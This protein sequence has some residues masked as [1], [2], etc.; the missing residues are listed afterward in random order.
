MRWSDFGDGYRPTI[1]A[2][3][4]DLVTAYRSTGIPNITVHFE[5]TVPRLLGIGGN[6]YLGWMLR[7]TGA[8]AW[9]R[10]LAELVPE[11]PTP[12]QRAARGARIL[13]EAR[14]GSQ[15]VRSLVLTSEA[16]SFTGVSAAAV[17]ERVLGGTVVPGFQTPASLLGADFALS[18]GATLQDLT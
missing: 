2:S 12:Q 15:Q 8:R 3:W 13:G 17:I 7:P 4:G 18:V 6:Q 11:G 5:A 1:A 10:E 16:Y 9:L 14:R